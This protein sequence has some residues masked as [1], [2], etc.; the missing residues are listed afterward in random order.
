LSEIAAW[1]AL[2]LALLILGALLVWQTMRLDRIERQYKALM[3]GSSGDQALAL[4]ELVAG[5]G[6]RLERTRDDLDALTGKV[7]SMDALVSKSVQHVG[8]VRFNPFQDTGGDQSFALAL[9]DKKGDGVVISS[10]HSRTNTRFYAKPIKGWTAQTSL[11]EEEAKA[12]QLAK[13]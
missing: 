13:T 7:A 6:E 4:G 11:S 2:G 5:Q 10:L 3:R 1:G 9:L 12:V 8:L